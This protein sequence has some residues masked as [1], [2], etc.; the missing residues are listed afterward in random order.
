VVVSTQYGSFSPIF[1]GSLLRPHLLGSRRK[2]AVAQI[3]SLDHMRFS[4]PFRVLLVTIALPVV[5][6]W[7]FQSH[8]IYMSTSYTCSRCR[9]IQR[10]TTLFGIESQ[11]GEQTD[12]S[13]WFAQSHSQHEHHW[14]W[15]GTYM[16]YYA[17]GVGRACGRQHAVW[18]FQPDIQRQ[19]VEA[20]SPA[21]LDQ[22]YAYMDSADG[23]EQKKG[24]DMVWHRVMGGTK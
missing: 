10:I 21:E 8:V 5:T 13:R 3:F 12:Y 17:L 19:F 7:Y 6:F 2:S 14:C 16:N 18:Q 22:F 15:C 20:A 9:A 24:A 4:K 1:S 23:I 11:W